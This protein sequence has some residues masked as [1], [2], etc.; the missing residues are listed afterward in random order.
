[1]GEQAHAPILIPWTN[2]VYIWQG[3]THDH[4][5]LLPKFQALMCYGCQ[6]QTDTLT[7]STIQTI[8]TLLTIIM[9]TVPFDDVNGGVLRLLG[10][11]G[12]KLMAQLIDNIY[13]TGE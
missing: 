8:Y 4:P 12:L 11:D 5:N 2:F 9:I 13:E 3:K 6:K 10:E 1:M 7:P